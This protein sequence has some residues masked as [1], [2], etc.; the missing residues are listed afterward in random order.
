MYYLYAAKA[1]ILL[2]LNWFA[3]SL[4]ILLLNPARSIK[5][6]NLLLVVLSC[7]FCIFLRTTV[8]LLVHI[9]LY[10]LGFFVVEM[11]TEWVHLLEWQARSLH[12]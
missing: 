11:N 5:T 12:S 9:F 8:A 6:L 7:L 3:N 2:S 1:G 4:C 10:I